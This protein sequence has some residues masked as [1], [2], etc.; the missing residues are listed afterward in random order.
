MEVVILRDADAVAIKGAQLLIELV[1]Q[2]HDAVLGL[3]TGRTPKALYK[4][5]VRKHQNGE[6]SF[7]DVTTF[8]LDEYLGIAADDPQSYRSFMNNILFQHIDI[9]PD[10][11]YLPYCKKE[12]NPRTFGLVF[13]DDILCN[14]GI[15]LQ[16]LGIGRNGHIG[17]N[18]PASSL[19]SRTRVK[20]LTQRTLEDNSQLF[21]KNEFQPR[22]AMTM[23]IATILDARKILLLATGNEKA[24]AVQSM[25]EGPLSSMCPASALQLHQHVSVLM[26]EQAAQG[27]KNKDYYQWVYE[28][29]ESLRKQF[30]SFYNI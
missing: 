9:D 2:K 25:V 20:T 30:G 4:E 21:E 12:E 16:V 6:V 27:L 1:I 22:L 23:G 17:F 14:G 10:N 3:A 5:L 26:D 18:E 29:N 7:A 8:N 15:D 19:S 28:Q 13:E 24:D 11:T